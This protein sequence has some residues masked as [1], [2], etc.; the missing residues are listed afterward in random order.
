MDSIEVVGECHRCIEALRTNLET[1]S[2][3][4]WRDLK[5]RNVLLQ[6]PAL[7]H[8]PTLEGREPATGQNSFQHFA[9]PR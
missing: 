8:E 3:F 6:I 2:Q 9:P 5:E 4:L 7:C 1:F